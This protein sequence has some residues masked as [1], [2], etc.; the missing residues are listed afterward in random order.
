MEMNKKKN[1]K[2]NIKKG[3]KTSAATGPGLALLTFTLTL[4]LKKGAIFIFQFPP[5][6]TINNTLSTANIL[7]ANFTRFY[8]NISSLRH[9]TQLPK[10]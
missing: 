4:N 2:N 5:L 10:Q 9:L 3:E 6:T 8:Y 7:Y 1:K